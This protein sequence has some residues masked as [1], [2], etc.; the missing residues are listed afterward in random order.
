ML[1]GKIEQLTQ[2]KSQEEEIEKKI[3]AL[4]KEI[5]G[6]GD[7]H[8]LW[9]ECDVLITLKKYLKPECFKETLE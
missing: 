1:I 6:E 2:L 5:A 3:R 9:E 4:E 7:R 8:H